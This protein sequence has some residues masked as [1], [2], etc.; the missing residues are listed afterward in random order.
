MKVQKRYKTLLTTPRQLTPVRASFEDRMV[1]SNNFGI[2]RLNRKQS[3]R[4]NLLLMYQ[5][6]GEAGF[7]LK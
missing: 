4:K 3:L 5:N 6:K 7:V 2:S 1:K